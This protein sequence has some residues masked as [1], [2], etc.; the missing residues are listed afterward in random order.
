MEK[1]Q[2]KNKVYC[3]VIVYL[4][5]QI[6]LLAVQFVIFIF[7]QFISIASAFAVIFGQPHALVLVF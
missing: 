7:T 1:E 6:S 3:I 2:K 5:V 4:P